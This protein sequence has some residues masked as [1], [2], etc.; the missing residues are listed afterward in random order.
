MVFAVTAK[1]FL[2]DWVWDCLTAV[3]CKSLPFPDSQRA[4]TDWLIKTEKKNQ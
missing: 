2:Y 1:F 3:G 4:L